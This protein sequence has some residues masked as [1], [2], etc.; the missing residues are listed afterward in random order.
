[1]K[2]AALLFALALGGA[3]VPLPPA[4]MRG[5]AMA[6][7]AFTANPERL[8]GTPPAGM[9]IAGCLRPYPGGAHIMVVPNP[10]P[11]AATEPYARIVCH[12]MGHVNGW[13]HDA[14]VRR[15]ER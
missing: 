13:V 7:V 9:R 8:C 12:E 11:Y 3:A 5:D 15:A 1:M 10:C 6:T 14:P 2:S 4:H